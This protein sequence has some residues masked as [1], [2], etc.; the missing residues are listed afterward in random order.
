MLEKELQLRIPIRTIPRAVFRKLT[1]RKVRFVFYLII[2]FFVVS[3]FFIFRHIKK[4]M[5]QKEE[6]KRLRDKCLEFINREV[7]NC[8]KLPE[9]KDQN[10]RFAT[11]KSDIL[12]LMPIKMTLTTAVFHFKTKNENYVIKRVIVR[13]DSPTQED[14]ISR[15]LQHKNIIKTFDSETTYFVDHNNKKQRIIWLFS[16]FLKEK[17]GQRI[18]NRNEDVIRHIMRDT[19]VA[20]KFLHDEMNFV[21]LDLKIAN[22]MGERVR[23]KMV[24]KLIDFGYSRDFNKERKVLNSEL[25]IPGK[26]Y[27]T[28][29]YKPPEVVIENKHGKPSDIWCV[30]AIAWF[31]SLGETPFYTSKGE[32]DV[33]AYRK[34]LRGAT[35]HFFDEDTTVELKHFI[36]KC[37]NRDPQARYT[38][39]QLLDHPF[40]TGK[41]IISTGE[42]YNDD[43]DESLSYSSTGSSSEY[44]SS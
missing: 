6:R 36:K 12:P 29:P 21:H 41:S 18:V 38:A 44:T 32:K 1:H 26:S 34:F 22:I 39:S 14:V 37:M 3:A 35:K 30:G 8:L 27:G 5:M 17:I 28:F 16:E 11:I 10:K 19:L 2:C 25:I 31:L 13:E 9:R 43:S 15:S 4:I 24:Y 42:T 7:D 23:S 20:L 33:S 40:I